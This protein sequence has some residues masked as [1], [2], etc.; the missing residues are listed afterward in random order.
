MK[1]L[2]A[3]L[4]LFFLGLL[5]PQTNAQILYSEDFETGTT[6]P[7]N[8]TIIDNDTA[9]ANA[10]VAPFDSWNLSL[11][12]LDANNRVATVASWLSTPGQSDDWMITP[13]ISGLTGAGS[14][15]WEAAS[16]N[17]M[18]RDGY[19]VWVTTTI[20]GTTPTISDFTTNGATVFTI[21]DEDTLLTPH[22]VSLAAYAGQNVYIA[23][24]NNSNDD[25]LLS[26]DNIVVE[27]VP[28]SAVFTTVNASCNNAN[29]SIS[30][31]V[32]GGVAPYTYLWDAAAGSQTTATATNLTAGI[33]GVTVTDAAGTAISGN[34]PLA[35]DNFETI[36]SEDFESVAGGTPPP[37]NMTVIDA[38]AAAANAGLPST[39]LDQW[40]VFGVTVG[41]VVSNMAAVASWLD[42][43]GIAD[44]WLI[45][46]QITGVDATTTLSWE[47]AAFNASFPDGYEV[48]VTSTIAGT[49][50][51]NTDFT[52]NG[53]TVFTIAAEDTLMTAHTVS[54]AAYANQDIYVA[55]RNNSN[56]KFILVVD[57]ISIQKACP[58]S[59]VL[60][61]TTST[62]AT[63]GLDNGTATVTVTGGTA[64]YTYL[65]D[66]NAGN[67]TTATAINLIG[68]ITYS[69]T[70]T[71]ANNN[72]ATSIIAVGETAPVTSSL[73]V[74]NAI[75][76]FG[77]NNASIE[78]IGTGG[79]APYTYAWDANTGNQTTAIATN[80][81]ANISYTVTIT[82]GDGCTA[83]STITLSEPTQL[84]ATATDNG[85]ATATVFGSGGTPPYTYAWSNG[86]TMVTATGLMNNTDYGVTVTDSLGCTAVDSVSITGVPLTVTT[87]SVDATCGQ[88]NGSASAVVVGGTGP[89]TYLWD[90]NAANQTTPT[91]A[92]LMGGNYDVTITDAAGITASAS[93][94]VTTS[95]AVT[96]T[97]S[98]TTDASCFGLADGTATVVGTGGTAPYTYQW[99]AN[100]GSQTSAT[101]TNLTAGI[102]DVTVTGSAGCTG[103]TS[104]TISE[105]TA[106][107]LSVTDNMDGTATAVVTGGVSPYVYLW[108]ANAAN[109]T[110][111]TATGLANATY[112][113]TVT[114]ANGCT[115]AD[116]VDATIINITNINLDEQVVIYPNP[117]S[118]TL[119][120]DFDLAA[121]TTVNIRLSSVLGQEVISRNLEGVSNNTIALPIDQL[122]T[123]VYA[124]EVVANKRKKTFKVVIE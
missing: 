64:P 33:Y 38:D 18:F 8:M 2:N 47:A 49:T 39:L 40:T 102:Y 7:T 20:A 43:P 50:P 55:F 13:Q 124:L 68:N 21:A 104:V 28:P 15:S 10:N 88:S 4:W 45:T 79:T 83:S 62:N 95:T 120:V 23:F 59:T 12:R 54:L 46:P 98:S 77:D 1:E 25:L 29:G 63:C 36:Y 5:I 117:A 65:W 84:T 53:A 122:P 72:S 3:L 34:I 9:S 51:T 96:A 17:N 80:L 119:W 106:L 78:A 32:S 81:S 41:P 44:D 118:S 27:N 112:F 35:N 61:T 76:C 89:Y 66:V 116:S 92:N 30:L 71:D 87:T 109:Q 93:V 75:N 107:M 111:A 105:P 91:A 6:M 86:Q 85:N 100:A 99:D 103:V 115:M 113:V 74:V 70:V 114:D 108:D 82:D 16:W 37:A 101:A 90:A 123:G 42:P 110:T 11:D 26:V 67:Q 14:L 69:V 57:N 52:T 73:T 97:I 22:T 121:A 24:R 19:E 94:S 60:L 48:W 58:A 31:T 56:D